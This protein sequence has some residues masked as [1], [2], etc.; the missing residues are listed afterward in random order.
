MDKEEITSEPKIKNNKTM[1][2]TNNIVMS[3]PKPFDGSLKNKKTDLKKSSKKKIIIILTSVLI[4]GLALICFAVFKN[5]TV[6]EEFEELKNFVRVEKE[7]QAKTYTNEAI[8]KYVKWAYGDEWY[9]I[10][11]KPYGNSEKALKFMRANGDYFHAIIGYNHGTKSVGSNGIGGIVPDESHYSKT[12][13]DTY[14]YEILKN[15]KNEV[16]QLA[17][18]LSLD[19]DIVIEN[20]DPATNAYIILNNVTVNRDSG[21]I[22]EFMVKTSEIVDYNINPEMKKSKMGLNVTVNISG[23]RN[24]PS[25]SL[26]NNESSRIEHDEDYYISELNSQITRNNN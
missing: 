17:E 23:G 18:R 22:A 12:Y 7:G 16:T 20:R 15:H 25:L 11:E 26:A 24:E 9:F 13:R 10:E 21:K 3:E 4:I 5:D 8:E 1:N 2:E 19:A 6:S 14:E